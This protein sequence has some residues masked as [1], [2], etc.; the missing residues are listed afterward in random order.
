MRGPKK[1]L[2]TDVVTKHIPAK[3]T[4]KACEAEINQKQVGT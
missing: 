4:L 3:I 1:I 2:D